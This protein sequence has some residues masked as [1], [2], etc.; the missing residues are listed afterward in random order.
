MAE[1]PTGWERRIFGKKGETVSSAE[2]PFRAE[3]FDLEQLV[4]HARMLAATHKVIVKPGPNPLL[5]RL[6][7][8]EKV[9]RAYNEDTT[10]VERTRRLTPAAEWLLDNF[11]LIREEIQT[12]RRHLPKRYSSEL[13]RLVEGP[14]ADYPRVYHIALELI[15][16]VDGRVDSDQLTRFIAA[17]QG[18]TPLKLGE[19]WA[20]PIM[21]RL[22]L[23]ENLRRVAV[24]L[25]EGR[26][27]RDAADHWSDRLLDTAQTQPANLIIE[28]ARLAQSKPDISSAFV[29]E[30]IRRLQGQSP[31]L[32]LARNWIEQRIA[33]R[34]LTIEQLIQLESQSQAADQVSI[35]N[36]I[37][38][39]RTLGAVDWREFVETLSGVEQALRLDPVGVYGQMDFLTRD[40]YRHVVEALARFSKRP[41]IEVAERV[42][43]MAKQQVSGGGESARQG[44]VGYYLIDKGF[45]AFERS[46]GARRPWRVRMEEGVKRHGLGAY[47]GLIGGVTLA[48]TAGIVWKE[49]MLGL[50]GWRLWL[51]A[52]LAFLPATQFAVALVN[53]IVT[54]ILRPALLPRLDYS[55]GIPDRSL[56]VVAVPTLLTSPRAV[57]RLVDDLEVRYLG[58]RDENVYFA[59]LTDFP[60]APS[61]E[62]PD[63]AALLDRATQGVESLNRRYADD[64]PSIF[65]LCH[66]PRK[67]NPTEGVWMGYE[68]KRGKLADL[69]ALIQGKGGEPFSRMVGDIRRIEGARYVITLDTDTGLP[70]ET[71]R[72]LAA[73]LAHPLN[74]PVYNPDRGIVTEGYTILQP[75]V[76]VSLPSAN[77]S[78]F[79]RLFAGDAGIDPY[80]RA[81]SDVYQDL[82]EEGS[83]IGKGIYHVAMFEKTLA[84]RFPENRI[85]SHDLVESCHARSALVGDVELFE[86]FPSSLNSEMTRRHRWIRGD[87]QIAPWLRSRVP[88]QT[89]TRL[90]NPLTGVSQWKIFDN[91]RRSLVPPAIFA[92]LVA[93]WF[94]EPGSG[95]VLTLALAG[96]LVAP[97]IFA[98]LFELARKPDEMPWRAHSARS[99]HS[100][101]R[102]ASQ[103]LSILLF[104]PY[105]SWVNL[106][107]VIRTAVRMLITRKHLLSWQTHSEGERTAGK[108]LAAFCRSMF[109][110][111][112][113]AGLLFAALALSKPAALPV[114]SLFLVLWLVSPLIA[115]Y[116]SQP[117]KVRPPQLSPAQLH[118][119]RRVARK[120]WRFFETF[121]TAED[122]WLP[123]DNWQE[124]PRPT[125][126]PRTSPTNIG[127]GLLSS[128]AAHDFG[129]ITRNQ[130]LKRTENTFATLDRMERHRGHFY[131]WYSTRTLQPLYPL[132]I[133]TVD[134]GNLAGHLLTLAGGFQ[135]MPRLIFA[136]QAVIRGLEDAVGLFREAL[137]SSASRA[138][139]TGAE[140]RLPKEATA[141]LQI[142]D[143]ELARPVTDLRELHGVCQRVQRSAAVVR[144]LLPATA[145]AEAA[146]WIAAVVKLCDDQ[147][148]ELT[149]TAP[150]LADPAPPNVTAQGRN[151]AL[152]G[153]WQKWEIEWSRINQELSLNTTVCLET[154]VKP[155]IE[156]IVGALT[157]A[158]AS[159]QEIEWFG[160]LGQRLSQASAFA[161]AELKRLEGLVRKCMEFSQMDFNFLYQ[162]SR[163]LFTIGFNVTTHHK[164]P[165]HYDLLASEARLT[166]YMAIA[167]GQVRQD[168]WFAL[169]RL[170]VPG[171]GSSAVLVSWSGSMFEYL[172]PLLITPTYPN[173][174]LD[175]TYKGV[176]ARQ[177]E[178]G[179]QRG[180]P[181]GLSESAYHLTDAQQNYQY[182]AFGVPGLGLKRGLAGDLVIA[183]YATLLGLMVCPEEAVQNLE[184]LSA[185][186]RE[187]V[188]GFYEAVDY[189]A[190]RL[191]PGYSSVTVRCFMAHHQGMSLLSLA[192]LL[193]DKPMQRRFMSNPHFKASDLLLHER[194]P[195]VAATE[196]P[197]ELDT[198]SWGKLTSIPEG[199]IRV[200]TNPN[201]AAPAVH[202]LSNGRYHLMITSAGSGYSRWKDLAITRWREDS[203]RDCWGSFCYL[204][205]V[206]TGRYWSAGY[207][208]TRQ[209][210]KGYE[211]IFTQ[212]RAELRNRFGEID[213]HLQ[214][215]VSPED[216][217]ELRR[218]T[219]TN[220]GRTPRTLEITSY[221]E[222]VLAPPA[223]DNSHP[224]FSNLFVQTQVLSELEAVL[225]VRRPRSAS[226]AP[227]WLFHL[228]VVHGVP[229]GSMS[230]ETDRSKFL[231]RLRTPGAPLAMD[232]PGPLSNSIGSVLDPVLAIRRR[233]VLPPESEVKVDII[234][235]IAE[236][237]DQA[238]GLIRKFRD[239]HLGERTIELAWTHSQVELRHLNATENEAQLFGRL[240]SALIY[241]NPYRRASSEILL[242][243]KRG[244]SSLWGYNIS[245]DLPIV[246][247]RMADAKQMD[248]LKQTVQAHAYWR[249]KG[250][251]A[252]LVILNED[253]SGYRQ[254]LQDQIVSLIA[255]GIEA[256]MLDKP[257][258]IFVRR[259]DQM[260]AEDRVLLL[261]AA[262]IVLDQNGVLPEQID[263]RTQVDA[264]VPQL[265]VARGRSGESPST[266][267]APADLIF[268]NGFGGFARDGREYVVVLREKQAT[269]APWVNVIANAQLGTVISE[270]GAAYTWAENAHEFRLTPWYNDPV[271][272]TSGEAFYIRDEQSGQFWSPT[273]LPA[274]GTGDYRVRHGFGYTIFE[275][276]EQ[277]ISSELTVYVAVDAPV[278]FCRLK[279]KNISG[280]SRRLGVFGYWEFVLG[281]L[282]SKSGM[283]VITSV[284]EATGT[285]VARN[286]YHPEFAG[287][288]AFVDLAEASRS[289]TGDRTEF[290]GRNGTPANPASLYRAHLSGKTGAGLDA[291][292]ALFTSFDLSPGAEKECI[293]TMG[294]G[295][296]IEDTR[297]LV[298]RFRGGAAARKA[299][300]AVSA[301]WNRTLGSLVV[302]TPDPAANLLANGWLV[303]QTLS[304]RFWART[305]FYQS[306]GA[307]GFRD[308]LQDVMGLLHAEP[309]LVREHLLRASSRQFIEGDVQHWWH[310]PSGR[311]V[312]THFSDDYLWLPY[313]VCRYVRATGDSAVL[314]E[315]RPFLEGRLPRPDEE[316]Y[317]DLHPP[318]PQTATLYAHCVRAIEHG[319]RF[320]AHGLPL[321]GCGDWNDGMNLIGAE[322]R[323]ESVWLAF[324]LYD[325][326]QQF[327]AVARVKGDASFAERCL[328]EATRLRRNIEEQAWDGQWYCRA[329]FDN[330]EPLGSERNMEC[331]IDSLP[332][333][334]SILS[335]AGDP[336]RSRMGMEAVLRRL[337]KTES[338][339]IQLFTPP[340]DKSPLN[341][342]YIKGYVPGV[343]ENGGQYTHAAIWTVMAFAAAGDAETAWKLF[344]MINPVLHGNDRESIAVY[345]VEPYVVAADVYAV[346]P[347]TG[348][349]GWTWYTGSAGWMYR[350]IIESFLGVQVEGSRL[351]IAPSVPRDWNRFRVKYRYR[352]TP[353]QILVE[354]VDEP[355]MEEIV[356]DGQR[357]AARYLELTDDRAEHQVQMKVR[358]TV[359]AKV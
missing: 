202:L 100:G 7:A 352:S 73:T 24:R 148:E 212:G 326:L 120:T 10:K 230:I 246:V 323:G 192:Y 124:V 86:D 219:L 307:Y 18:I 243:N 332:Q 171:A 302:E 268:F 201:S 327:S 76:G 213:A 25:A 344:T 190:A 333:S 210:T 104:V 224:A 152:G 64:R 136:R 284:D 70:A 251:A 255:S 347:H 301:F 85:L 320:G 286:S 348:R 209:P 269:P 48:T 343:R 253:D 75:R 169:G 297:E 250:L 328:A 14:W 134:S 77:R 91:L 214:V 132:Y 322:G 225:A 99:L 38:S 101:A 356:L 53:W 259:A 220:R 102:H 34:G 127:L 234:Y 17:Y 306:G 54:V 130:L 170:L 188:Y 153:L 342:G 172:M 240:A 111:P 203:T 273:A 241:A 87:W 216:D 32:Q 60:D 245:G 163:D 319:L 221:A 61:E 93:G 276:Q 314:D 305:G 27:E 74:E 200:F 164:D 330:G 112:A 117:L 309:G 129:Y 187:G 67:W 123:P 19:L 8:N 280:R 266:I 110:A 158:A 233:V 6:G 133:S 257:G 90:R 177:I 313:S 122:N 92:L 143:A 97:G 270:S 52:L 258:G 21:L 295:R 293:F 13:P 151:P 47:L 278:K 236:T 62:M 68:R 215:T 311:G 345:K 22:A 340:F 167:L 39:L 105:E 248:M 50:E 238:V 142:I 162:S 282:R 182:R 228:M 45:A 336:E 283:H 272:D 218:L 11:Y 40:R 355:Q 178:Y 30:F 183:P 4:E 335:G 325:V 155:L 227:P 55:M 128:L 159:G 2:E 205:D 83:F 350:L 289:L 141:E 179:R 66:R 288:V 304:C 351:V 197:A 316:A 338:R 78:W 232:Q 16:H 242:Q 359:R 5:G 337:V 239:S 341:P 140:W 265:M 256:Q 339:L 116:I 211:A 194:V 139:G 357:Q 147:L 166:S 146:W 135:E 138:G 59:L 207:Q 267:A 57:D 37:T 15:A 263:R 58:N 189:Q 180:V 69:N 237:Q 291:C 84:H 103:M 231:G 72:K 31:S 33:E 271:S 274:R 321:I 94:L 254:A 334:W 235:G 185:E 191:P 353:Y 285:L 206:E 175:E 145:N 264:T 80:T 317:Y 249:L 296:G 109:A 275:H 44:H 157:P 26:R 89:G 98:A 181:W 49:Q 36:S 312:R 217:V 281:E 300:D 28:V 331:Q 247:L 174:L 43:E 262:R 3:L 23:I 196:S 290:L 294:A 186:G 63:D 149:Q 329:F 298:K 303:Y 95:I 79:S 173:T 41:E 125:I 96:L 9:L 223:A 277:G 349:G 292:G 252:D 222:V 115:Y 144:S 184:R 71:A 118:Y 287:R 161:R 35:G 81:V 137:K 193:L 150:W 46:I 56:T 106:D 208:P 107:A 199:T 119:L 165:S 114:A 354:L 113:A 82:F 108:S 1:T 42:V 198:A 315:T 131:N 318:S 310:P 88:G 279:I 204:C 154:T 12:T 126:A 244:Q 229:A 308:Q 121:V 160:R 65:L 176:V 299:F 261:A 324:F 346:E 195:Q 29:A 51:I 168:H 156:E 358:R 260:A 226:E 20:V